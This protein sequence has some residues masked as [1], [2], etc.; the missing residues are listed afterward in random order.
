[1]NI[2]ELK[3]SRFLRKEDCN[4]DTGI[5]VTIDHVQKMNVAELGEK[6]EFK[7]CLFF[8][9]G[10]KPMVLNSTNG[11]LIARALGSRESDDWTGKSIQ[12]YNEANVSFAGQLVGGIRVRVRPAKPEK[13]VV[14]NGDEPPPF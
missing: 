12:L 8:R 14:D 3:T 11:Q 6:P 7:W 4:G 10:I 2:N 13:F 5:D 1:M 9:D